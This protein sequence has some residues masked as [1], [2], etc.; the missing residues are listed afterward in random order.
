[1][2]VS[3]VALTSPGSVVL[4]KHEL[5]DGWE[6]ACAPPSQQ[7]ELERLE[8]MPAR[9][10]GTAA[11][12]LRS[13]ERWQPGDGHDFDADDWWFR[14]R[15]QI[16]PAMPGEEL[17]LALDGVATVAEVYLNGERILESDSMFHAHRVD[18]TDRLEAD[19]R[20]EICC[21]ALRPLL[22]PRRKPRARWRTKLVADGNLRFF[23]TMLLGRAPGFAP[24]PAC[25]GPW[26]PIRI[27]RR[28]LLAV[29][30]LQLRPSLSDGLARLAV[31]ARLHTIEGAPPPSNAA[32]ELTG[33]SG[34]HRAE[35]ALAGD[36]ESVEVD[37]ELVS[38]GLQ[39]WWPHTHGTPALY[40]ARL[41]LGVDGLEAGIDAGRVGF[42][43]LRASG[44]LERDGVRLTINGVSLFARGAVWTPVDLAEPSSR[45]DSLSA[46]VAALVAA[47]MNMVRVPGTGCYESHAFYDACDELGILVWQ[48]FMFAN[49]D[50]PEQDGEFMASVEREARQVVTGL[51]S[52]PSLA[53]FCGGSE[54]GQQVAM[55]G[56]D[57]EIVDG[58]LYGELLPTVI[59]Q[60][61]LD[62]PYIPSTPWGGDLPFRPN[63]GVSH[64]YGVGA[65]LRPLE[66]ARRAEVRFAAECLAFSNVPDEQALEQME[67]PGGLV[68]HHPR[69]KAGVPRDVGAGWDFED[70]R[71]HYLQ[72]LFDT[73]PAALR[74]SDHERYLDLSRAV[75]GEVMSDV[76]GEWRRAGSSCSGGLVLWLTD[77][78]PGAGWGLLDHC[79]RPKVAY[80]HLRRALAPV[81]VWSTDEGLGGIEVHLAN[82]CAEPLEAILRISLYREREIQVEEIERP[83][84]LQAHGTDSR[85]LEDLLGRF[86]DASWAYRFGP[87]AQDLIVLTLESEGTLISQSCRNV[88]GLPI[89]RETAATMGLRA[90]VR[91]A[92][93]DRAE[94]TIAARRFAY[95][96]RVEVP[97]FVPEDD[98]FSV[99]PGHSRTISFSRVDRAA[100]SRGGH[101]T[102]LN[103][104]G[105]VPIVP[106]EFP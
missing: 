72:L 75:T 25:V 73:D 6:A 88:A 61:G 1:M 94:V 80:H 16:E 38:S 47:G 37:G 106:E 60:A 52:R 28:R 81:A 83:V 46:A 10:P 53:V 93:D 62:T 8:W 96:V 84:S 34:T 42:R 29:D 40:R 71:D 41:L 70:V 15:F 77:L 64:Y 68:C 63:A 24:E 32:I 26:K 86:V 17:I 50:Y 82:D 57:S 51:A 58:P 13:A 14:T 30:E 59:E 3:S 21:R 85:N 103:L 49:L 90:T 97:G 102:A 95:G 39:P 98:A 33:P 89:V 69:W 35:L 4:A 43:S 100:T 79:L 99:E 76:F 65:Y 78:L 104:A 5:A 23:R 31:K 9:V 92:G 11:A 18:I 2:S 19:N 45:G 105:R 74:S 20:L 27:E 54:V 7:G 36:G 55:L 87:P 101:L 44:E 56:L 48:D 66:D 67:V 12:A 22:Q 91:A